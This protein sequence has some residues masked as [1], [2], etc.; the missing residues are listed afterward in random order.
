MCEG[1]R[2]KKEKT[3]FS[4][5]KILHCLSLQPP[6]VVSSFS[7]QPQAATLANPFKIPLQRKNKGQ[8]KWIRGQRLR[9]HRV[10]SVSFFWP[11]FCSRRLTGRIIA[12]LIYIHIKYIVEDNSSLAFPSGRRTSFLHS[13]WLAALRSVS[14]RLQSLNHKTLTD[15]GLWRC[16]NWSIDNG[17]IWQGNTGCISYSAVY[18]SLWDT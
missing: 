4:F 17:P 9:V 1:V 5:F 13:N 3:F 10:I 7:Q 14:L 12:R 15:I 16:C 8:K 6:N 18:P 2:V 11:S